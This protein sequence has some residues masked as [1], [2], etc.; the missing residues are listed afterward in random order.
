MFRVRA[1]GSLGPLFVEVGR[2]LERERWLL[3]SFTERPAALKFRPGWH[4]ILRSEPPPHLALSA[5][6][7]WRP[8]R[9]RGLIEKVKRPDYQGGVWVTAREIRIS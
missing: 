8:I 3:A 4:V 7:T 5:Q 1:D 6:R 2:V 9:W